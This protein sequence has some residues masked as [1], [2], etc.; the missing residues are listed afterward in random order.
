V[1]WTSCRCQ[2]RSY[3]D[4]LPAGFLRRSKKRRNAFL[5]NVFKPGPPSKRSA[6]VFPRQDRIFSVPCDGLRFQAITAEKVCKTS[7]FGMNQVRIRICSPAQLALF[8]HL[9]ERSRS[10]RQ[11]YS[12]FHQTW[13]DSDPF[14]RCRS[15]AR[16]PFW[17]FSCSYQTSR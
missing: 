5:A 15:I 7:F 2:G 4:G 17:A 14:N 10:T 12:R 9:A 6:S 11:Q 13:K 16:R 3:A 8:T 1:F